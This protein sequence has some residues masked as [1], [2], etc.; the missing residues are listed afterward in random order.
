MSV[1]PPAK[2]NLAHEVG[3]FPP[4]DGELVRE[5][6]G[7]WQDLSHAQFAGG[8]IGGD[9]A[10]KPDPVLAVA[11]GP[12]GE[13]AWAVGGYDGTEDA[14]GQGTQGTASSSRAP[15]WQTASIW[16]YDTAGS[17]HPAALTSNAPNLPAQPG[18]V[19]FAFFTSPMC[20]TSCAGVPDAQPDV[21]L[22]AAAQQIATYAAQ[23][24]GPAFAMLGGNAVGPVE[25]KAWQSGNGEGDFTHLPEEL[26]PLGAL[27][28]FAAL[29]KF[30][31]VPNNKHTTGPWSEA[32]STAPPPFGS[33]PEG[34]RDLGRSHRGR[35]AAK[36]TA[37]TPSTPHRM[38][39]RRCG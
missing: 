29:G 32:F 33:G 21:N 7:G 22:K 26:A 9:G 12:D 16:R 31:H 30:D 19:S 28:T 36:C 13:H 14:A 5:T 37:T 20:R 4:G 25:G 6:D 1:A 24:G 15:G 34:A 35:R 23:P 8:E 18:T 11:T 10:V 38:G 3:G 27:P 2:A 39:P 17:A